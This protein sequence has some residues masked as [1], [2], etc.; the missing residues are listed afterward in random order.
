MLM[1]D[2]AADPARLVPILHYDGMPLNAGF[3]VNGVLEAM[4]K[5]QAA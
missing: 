4:A 2:I 5:G 1:L 3:V